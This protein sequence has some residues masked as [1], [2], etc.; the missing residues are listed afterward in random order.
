MSALPNNARAVD[1]LLEELLRWR[2]HDPY[3]A[4]VRPDL[5]RA[6]CPVCDAPDRP[7]TITEHGRGAALR[8]R[9][10]CTE[11]A[12]VAALKRAVMPRDVEAELAAAEARAAHNLELG[13]RAAAIARRMFELAERRRAA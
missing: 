9:T 7:V 10:G 3:R 4:T 8:C 6:D 12:I 2:P 5:W 11:A 13:E 1:L